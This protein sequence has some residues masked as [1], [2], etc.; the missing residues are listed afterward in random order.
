MLPGLTAV[1]FFRAVSATAIAGGPTWPWGSVT[2]PLLPPSSGLASATPDGGRQT[3]V[4]GEVACSAARDRPLA[5]S[6]RSLL[7]AVGL[8]AVS[9]A[10]G[11]QRTAGSFLR[12]RLEMA[13][14]G[15][16]PS[17]PR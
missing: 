17:H 3:F 16:E 13:P 8:G 6:V 12:E 10:T 7:L 2:T 15:I 9:L 11:R 4:L 1:N 14:A 5:L